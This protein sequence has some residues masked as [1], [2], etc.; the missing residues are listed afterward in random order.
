[1]SVQ[2]NENVNRNT[3]D[4][5]AIGFSVG[6]EEYGIPLSSVQEIITVPRITRVP[7]APTYIKGV[8][9]L[10]GNVIPVIDV[11]RRFEIGATQIGAAARVVVVE[12]E[13]EAV[14]LLAEGVSKVTRFRSS[15]LQPPPPLVAGIAAEFLDGIVR[16]R[17]R[18]VIFLNLARTLDDEGDRRQGRVNAEC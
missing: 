15:D 14:G 10:H 5:H 18:F 13:D 17:D 16:L 6:S 3:A 9:N 1:M 8:I 7:K 11:A 12:A 4:F 2:A